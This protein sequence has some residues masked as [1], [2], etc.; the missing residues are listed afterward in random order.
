MTMYG[1]LDTS[2]GDYHKY[3]G[4]TKQELDW[5]RCSCN[6]LEIRGKFSHVT[7]FSDGKTVPVRAIIMGVMRP[8]VCVCVCVCVCRPVGCVYTH[9]TYLV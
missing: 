6:A 1:T 9:V 8:A 4:W 3:L 7:T 2:S 5:R